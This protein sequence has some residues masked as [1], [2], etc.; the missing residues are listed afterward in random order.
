MTSQYL[1]IFKEKVC[2]NKIP[3]EE[4][5]YEYSYEY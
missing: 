3:D 2:L 4:K 5:A 1:S